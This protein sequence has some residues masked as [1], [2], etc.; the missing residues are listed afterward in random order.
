MV[1][2]AVSACSKVC[3]QR[4][5]HGLP[6][7]RAAWSAVSACSMVC[8][9]RVQHG[10]PSVRA[11][12]SAVSACSKVCRQCVQYGLLSVRAVRMHP[13]MKRYAVLGSREWRWEE[14][15][16]KNEGVYVHNQWNCWSR[17]L[18]RNNTYSEWNMNPQ[19]KA[20]M[21]SIVGQLKH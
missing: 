13:C 4:V 5:Q 6:S 21:H 8:R 3:R 17:G 2:S 19:H 10:L 12:W 18:C 7:V 16:R 20:D 11:A 1:W 14:M 15:L 9:Q